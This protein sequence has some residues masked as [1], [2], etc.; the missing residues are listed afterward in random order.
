MGGW[1][2]APSPVDYYTNGIFC[3]QMTCKQTESDEGVGY[4]YIY[5]SK[6]KKLTIQFI[7]GERRFTQVPDAVR[8]WSWR[9]DEQGGE[10]KSNRIRNER[11][12]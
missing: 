2:N 5:K 9:E 4:I 6:T 11:Q 12:Y 1:C 10:N 8:S 7:L 3:L